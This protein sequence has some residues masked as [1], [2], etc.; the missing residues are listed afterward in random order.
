MTRL[1][2]PWLL[3]II[4]SVGAAAILVLIRRRRGAAVPGDPM[5]V[6]PVRASS[7]GD[8]ESEDQAGTWSDDGGLQAASG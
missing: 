5:A 7:A 6:T 8:I 3:A 2:R 1:V 4:V